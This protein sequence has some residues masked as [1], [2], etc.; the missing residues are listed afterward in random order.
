MIFSVAVM[1]QNGGGNETMCSSV[2]QVMIYSR[3]IQ[4]QYEVVFLG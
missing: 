3:F 4:M 1:L 2:W